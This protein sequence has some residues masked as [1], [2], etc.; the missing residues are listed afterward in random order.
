[1]TTLELIKKLVSLGCSEFDGRISWYSNG[2]RGYLHGSNSCDK[3]KTNNAITQY[4]TFK[5]AFT[6]EKKICKECDRS[7]VRTNEA[8]TAIQSAT[9]LDTVGRTVAH[10]VYR[11]TSDTFSGYPGLLA[12]RFNTALRN[13]RNTVEQKGSLSGL[14]CW[15]NECMALIEKSL[16]PES[17]HTVKDESLRFSALSCLSTTLQ[18]RDYLS[19]GYLWGGTEATAICGSLDG[20]P[21]P[22]NNPL[23][24]LNAAWFTMHN[25]S[26][27]THQDITDALFGEAAIAELVGTPE[28]L[29]L[30]NF[31]STVLPDA[32]ETVVA[33]AT[34]AWLNRVT[35]I[36]REVSSLWSDTYDTY[37]S[38]CELVA[39]GIIGPNKVEYSEE[40]NSD[41][42]NPVILAHTVVRPQ[43]VASHFGHTVVVCPQIVATYIENICKSRHRYDVT[44][45][46]T[47]V[48]VRYVEHAETA[49]ALWSPRDKS[50]VYSS[51][52]TAYK[53]A[54]EL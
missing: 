9:F 18:S 40:T 7:L 10:L 28:S 20:Y 52:E 1:M 3:L 49:A 36:L 32:G 44:S 41:V 29:N 39:F 54:V 27:S 17:P 53:A 30:L 15:R 34:R 25:N 8:R 5:E 38:E 14:E 24:N 16:L 19:T 21:M 11:S 26:H 43:E 23:R 31:A 48:G 45:V 4:F 12:L 13:L 33:F 2:M 6:G 47:D 50:S 42:P 35:D 22:K 37:F 46:V 51:F